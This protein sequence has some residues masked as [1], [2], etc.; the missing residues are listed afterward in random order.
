MIRH[1]S[2]AGLLFKSPAEPSCTIVHFILRTLKCFVIYG[3]I[4]SF[5]LLCSQNGTLRWSSPDQKA[6]VKCVAID[7]ATGILCSSAAERVRAWDVQVCVTAST[8]RCQMMLSVFLCICVC[9]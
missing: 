3:L 4:V 7:T 2:S 8:V 6:E 9:M 1:D 5:P